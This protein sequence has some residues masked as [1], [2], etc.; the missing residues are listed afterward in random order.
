MKKGLLVIGLVLGLTILTQGAWAGNITIN[1]STTVLPIAQKIAEEFMKEFPDAKISISG[2]GS[3][4]G[5]KSLIDGMTDIANSSR[6]IKDKEVSLAIEKGKYPVPFAIAYDCIIPIVHPSNTITNLTL[7]QLKDL[8]MGNIKNW[9]EIGGPDRPVVVI[10][11]DTSSG[12]YEVWE[13]KVMK[14]E[15]VYPGALLQA[16]NGAIVQ[17]VSK[18]EN[19]IGYIGLGYLND[20]VKAVKVDG[21]EGTKVTTLNGTFPISRALFMFTSGWPQ[22]EIAQ[23]INYALHP[24]KGQKMV[25]EVGFVPLY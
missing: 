12:T 9:K 20:T 22:G 21:V 8:Y 16:S 15:K 18:N 19:A 13:E 1:G 14:Q 11:R 23:F 24:Q 5:I 3:G 10:S 6:F 17:A 25:E 7:D 4:N 2:G